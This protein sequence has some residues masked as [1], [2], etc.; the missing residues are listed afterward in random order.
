MINEKVSKTFC[1]LPWIHFSTRPNGHV[2]LCCT[3]NASSVTETNDKPH[4]GEIGVVRESDGVPSNFGHHEIKHIW[5]SKFMRNVRLQML[6]GEIPHACMKCFKEEAAGHS[7][8]RIWE[9]EVWAKL[10][11]LDKLIEETDETGRVPEKVYYFDLRFGTRCD[12]KCI[13]CSPNDS[14]M[15]IGDWAK[16]YPQIQDAHLKELCV[17]NEKGKENGGSIRWFKDNPKFWEQ[18]YE[19]IPNV[20]QMYMAGGEALIIKEYEEMLHRIIDMGYAGK[21]S[22]RYNSNGLK[23]TDELIDIWK[24]FY[25]VRFHF[26]IDAYDHINRYI[27]W[28][29]DWKVILEQLERLDNTPKN[30]EVTIACAVQL[31]NI[32]YIPDF[33]KWKL[34]QGYKKINSWPLGGGLINFHLVYHPAFLNVKVLPQWFKD[35]TAEKYEDFYEWLRINYRNDD[36]FICGNNGWGLPRLKGLISFMQSEDWSFRLHELREYITLMDKIRGTNFRETFPEM[37]KVIYA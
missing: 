3:A 28:P 37:E 18:L 8:K 33:I 34:K 27:R 15:W 11:D 25:R 20:K 4:G 10:L 36:E 17:W 21:M 5:N 16:L 29:T 14:S 35:K 22:L 23:L 30:I 2:R 9:T 12:L 7:S 31:L 26:S 32:Y 13:M 19:Q 24:Q 6:K 1:I